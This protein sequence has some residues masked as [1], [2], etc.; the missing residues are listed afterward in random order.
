MGV[1]VHRNKTL[2]ELSK[3]SFMILQIF[4]YCKQ[5]IYKGNS[6]ST[7]KV[8]NNQKSRVFSS[9]VDDYFKDYQYRE[10]IL[11]L[12][13][14]LALRSLDLTHVYLVRHG[15]TDHNIGNIIQEHYESHLKYKGKKQA[16][17]LGH[18][19]KGLNVDFDSVLCSDLRR[20][21]QT[22]VIMGKIIELSNVVMTPLLRERDYGDWTNKSFTINM[23]DSNPIEVSDN[24]SSLG[25]DYLSS[26]S[27][28]LAEDFN[29]MSSRIMSIIQQISTSEIISL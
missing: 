1:R 24:G 22:L 7:L 27:I 17:Y 29:C 9:S 19:L 3:T 12:L 16:E 25:W 10:T 28:P 15:Q 20:C 23:S 5:I 4:K 21:Q 11:Q 14:H 26:R 18:K 8:A 13:R 6:S 2:T